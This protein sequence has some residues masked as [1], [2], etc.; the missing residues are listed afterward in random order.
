LI[1]R[2]LFFFFSRRAVISKA[3]LSHVKDKA[4][5]FRLSI[6]TNKGR[7]YVI[8]APDAAIRDSWFEAFTKARDSAQR[9]EEL[10]A[11]KSLLSLLFLM[12]VVFI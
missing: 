2:G 6:R 12:C 11:C 7:N 4:T 8:T 3:L 1:D 5:K 10:K 9:P